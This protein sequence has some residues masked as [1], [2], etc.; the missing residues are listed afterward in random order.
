M[1]DECRPSAEANH[2]GL[3][4]FLVKLEKEYYRLHPEKFPSK[5]MA[6][7]REIRAAYRPYD[8]RPAAIKN[9]TDT[10]KRL[11][12]EL[13]DLMKRI[14]ESKL[15]LRERSALHLSYSYL[16]QHSFDWVP[17]ERDYYAGDWM[18]EPNIYCWRPICDVLVNLAG[19][20]STFKPTDVEGVE[21]LLEM[22]GWH[23]DTI[24]QYINNLKLGVRT[25]MVG[26]KTSCR[27]GLRALR[28]PYRNVFLYNETGKKYRRDFQVRMH[29]N[30]QEL[31]M[32]KR[33]RKL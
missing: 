7:S 20:A 3:T 26:S 17:Y 14:N 33:V 9:K 22:L 5:K 29:K 19:L 1:Q 12:E 23:N 2:S 13:G 27:A 8:A 32:R 6:S 30:A 25:G 15:K 11:R 16:L 28:R 31:F 10:T 21:R 24:V 4:A 18:L